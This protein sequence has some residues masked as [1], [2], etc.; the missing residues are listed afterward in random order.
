MDLTTP[1]LN[2]PY[3]SSNIL[4]QY[5]NMNMKDAEDSTP[6]FYAFRGNN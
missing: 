3:S 4:A 6:I 2:S 1:N 5:V